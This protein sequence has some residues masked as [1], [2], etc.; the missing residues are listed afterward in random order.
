MIQE[1][2][3][4]STEYQGFS[5]RKL[6]KIQRELINTLF[7][8]IMHHIL[9]IV[10]A[11]KPLKRIINPI[12]MN[13]DISLYE[14]DSQC[15]ENIQ[16]TYMSL[17]EPLQV[18]S[19]IPTLLKK[20]NF[21]F[22]LLSKCNDGTIFNDY[23]CLHTWIATILYDTSNDRGVYMFHLQKCLMN[24]TL[25]HIASEIN[26]Q[27]PYTMYIKTGSMASIECVLR[28][29][30]G[31]YDDRTTPIEEFLSQFTKK[32]S[33]S[34]TE[35]VLSLKEYI[36]QCQERATYLPEYSEYVEYLEYLK[37]QN[38]T[39]ESINYL[40]KHDHIFR[41]M[42]KYL[43]L[44]DS[45]TILY[46]TKFR[47]FE[48]YVDKTEECINKL[49]PLVAR[50]RRVMKNKPQDNVDFFIQLETTLHEVIVLIQDR[51]N[52]IN[53][54]DHVTQINH[55]IESLREIL[56][57]QTLIKNH[58]D[59]DIPLL[60]ISSM[61]TEPKESIKLNTSIEK[62]QRRF[63]K[64]SCAKSL[65]E[66]LWMQLTIQMLEILTPLKPVLSQKWKSM[67]NNHEE[68]RKYFTSTENFKAENL[69]IY[70]T[71]L[72]SNVNNATILSTQHPFTEN[73]TE[74]DDRTTPIEE[75]RSP[76]TEKIFSL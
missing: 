26:A 23:A 10:E 61:M 62:T 29:R 72:M 4:L 46:F 50:I 76:I 67:Y 3:K 48:L 54:K 33:Q 74:Y 31:Q 19:S 41:D 53:D 2:R 36:H 1:L 13:N 5:R 65:A 69:S 12:T 32:L 38:Y 21:L 57:I 58:P 22:D 34:T 63:N 51:I 30:I 75:F 39:P 49:T 20:Y 35:K 52:K 9:Q 45:A 56:E 7:L 55:I 14:Q 40:Q 59:P 60:S 44:Q 17:I 27:I 24:L 11:D 64:F 47:D 68:L 15:L 6:F 16:V 70:D 28:K 43:C 37:I 66:K 25:L 8:G 71:T 73:F 42:Q 18:M